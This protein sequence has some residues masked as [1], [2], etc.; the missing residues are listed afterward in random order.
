MA[1][2]K[3]NSVVLQTAER[4]LSGM[5]TIDPKLD[6]GGGC[7]TNNIEAKVKDVRKKLENY[8]SLLT[9]VDAAANELER[10]EKELN[11]LSVKVLPGVATRYD[12]ES[13]QYEMVGGIKPSERKRP[14]RRVAVSV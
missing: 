7:T 11:Y 2:P 13:D 6:L 1:R 14:R 5:K 10:A 8:N 9:T 4:R 3:K 12:K